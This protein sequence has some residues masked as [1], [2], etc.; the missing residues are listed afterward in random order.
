MERVG[1]PARTRVRVGDNLF[2]VI[3]KQSRQALRESYAVRG[4]F[5]LRARNEMTG[6]IAI[7]QHPRR[8]AGLPDC[9]LPRPTGYIMQEKG[10]SF[11]SF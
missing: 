5:A 9:T 3:T 7:A 10:V 6:G 11:G 2:C 4:T 8:R 1:E